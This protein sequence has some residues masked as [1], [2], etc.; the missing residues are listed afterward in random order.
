MPFNLSCLSRPVFRYLVA[1]WVGAATLSTSP[2]VEAG[3]SFTEGNLFGKVY[4]DADQDGRPSADEVG[5][6]GATIEIRDANTRAVVAT[7]VSAAQGIFLVAGLPVG[8]YRVTQLAL[9]GYYLPEPTQIVTVEPGAGGSAS[10]GNWKRGVVTGLVFSD[11]NANGLWDP[12]ETGLPGISVTLQASGTPAVPVLTSADG[13]FRFT[14]VAPGSIRVQAALPA[15]LRPTTSADVTRSLA[16]NGEVRIDMGVE[17][18][19]PH[20]PTILTQPVDREL[21][22]GDTGLLT[23][24][25]EGSEPFT[26]QWFKNETALSGATDRVLALGPVLPTDSGAYSVEVR[27]EAGVLRSRSATVVVVPNDPYLRWVGVAGLQPGSVEPQQDP[28]GD[29]LPNLFEFCLG[30][31]PLKSDPA[32]LVQFTLVAR[33]TLTKPAMEFRRVLRASG[34][35]PFLEA[36]EDLSHW[37]VVSS[38][39]EVVRTDA[40]GEIVRCVDPAPVL[41]HPYRYY[42]LGLVLGTPPVVPGR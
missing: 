37:T 39:V 11:D 27:N 40:D 33:G 35:A 25:A 16:D 3:F 12:E 1:L 14:G 5:L 2:T 41:G 19:R 29:G 23:V 20:P 38:T 28:D 26:Y 22:E 31:D 13:G 17:V 32:G 42:R 18:I 10:F 30:V 36:S 9:A 34:V 8:E 24:I 4:Y 21:A 7:R 15:N 6:E